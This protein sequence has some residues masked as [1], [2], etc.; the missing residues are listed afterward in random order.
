MIWHM[1]YR[2]LKRISNVSSPLLNAIW[3]NK[4][5]IRFAIWIVEDVHWIIRMVKDCKPFLCIGLFGLPFKSGKELTWKFRTTLHCFSH[6]NEQFLTERNYY[7]KIPNL[8]PIRIDF[9]NL[10]LK[11]LSRTLLNGNLFWTGRGF[12]RVSQRTK[13]WHDQRPASSDV[14]M[15]VVV[16]IQSL[17]IFQKIFLELKIEL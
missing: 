12:P 2:S 9:G 6:Y 3:I 8:R 13:I 10:K 11:L 15:F 4:Q 16:V 17:V 5:F 14:S 7:S 1:A